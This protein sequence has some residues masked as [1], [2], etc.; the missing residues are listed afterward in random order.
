MDFSSQSPF[1]LATLL[2][3]TFVATLPF[4]AWRA[5]C[6]KFTVKWWL[7]IHLIIPLIFLMRRWGGFSYWYIPLFLASTVLGQIVGGRINQTKAN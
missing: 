2:A 6:M 4:G 3:I 7:A 5:K 1:L